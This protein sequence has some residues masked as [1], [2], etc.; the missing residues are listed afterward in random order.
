MQR[1]SDALRVASSIFSEGLAHLHADR[2]SEALS[3]FEMVE[4][5]HQ[6]HLQPA[7]LENI[8]CFQQIAAVHDKLGNLRQAAQY[9]ERAKDQLANPTLVPTNERGFTS[10]RRRAELLK[11]VQQQLEMMPRTVE[12][13]VG[14]GV[15]LDDLRALYTSLTTAGDK[16][17]AAGD[18]EAAKLSFEQALALCR[19][20]PAGPTGAPAAAPEPG[21]GN[22]AAVAIADTLARLAEVHSRMGRVMVAEAHILTAIDVLAGDVLADEVARAEYIYSG[23]GPYPHARADEVAA[24]E[25]AAAVDDP[26]AAAASNGSVSPPPPSILVGVGN[27]DPESATEIAVQTDGMPPRAPRQTH[28]Q[29]AQHRTRSPPNTHTEGAQHPTLALTDADAQMPV[30]RECRAARYVLLEADRSFGWSKVYPAA[31]GVAEA[32]LV[33]ASYL[34]PVLADGYMRAEFVG[35]TATEVTVAAPGE[36]VW[37]VEPAAPV[38][39][40]WCDVL[41]Q[42]GLRGSVPESHVAWEAAAQE[43]DDA[44]DDAAAAAIQTAGIDDDSDTGGRDAAHSSLELDLPPPL[45]P[46]ATAEAAAARR[47][48]LDSLRTSLRSLQ[49]TPAY[50][51]ASRRAGNASPSSPFSPMPSPL[52]APPRALGAHTPTS[53]PPH[54]AA[55]GGE[56]MSPPFRASP[57]GAGMRT[58]PS[59]GSGAPVRKFTPHPPSYPPPPRAPATPGSSSNPPHRRHTPHPP[60]GPPPSPSGG[61]GASTP[62]RTP[63]PPT[64]ACATPVSSMASSSAMATPPDAGGQQSLESLHA[65]ASSLA[66]AA[67]SAAA[68][69]GAAQAAQSAATAVS[70]TQASPGSAGAGSSAGGAHGDGGSSAGPDGSGDSGGGSGSGG[71][72]GGG[73]GGGGGGG[74][75]SDGGGGSGSGG[76][77]SAEVAAEDEFAWRRDQEEDDGGGPIDDR[78]EGAIEAINVTRDAMTEAQLT[79]DGTQRKL[80]STEAHTQSELTRLQEENSLHLVKLAEYEMAKAVSAEA[81]QAAN[82]AVGRVGKAGAGEELKRSKDTQAESMRMAMLLQK[83]F[84]AL[85]P[86]FVYRSVLESEL[87]DKRQAV[88]AA[89]EEARA[90]RRAYNRSMDYLEQISL[91]IQTKEAEERAAKEKEADEAAMQQMVVGAGAPA[92]VDAA[93]DPLDAL[94]VSEAPPQPPLSA[95]AGTAARAMDHGIRNKR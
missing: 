67:R 44:R 66:L 47:E 8:T 42:S 77:A 5:I 71:G 7:S 39:D 83:T 37:K 72:G 50:S 38:V 81:A 59:G 32:G 48:R 26:P 95:E 4:N 20:R 75:G 19:S 93:A 13:K 6:K 91:E 54:A 29:G 12:P 92:A 80:A 70:N 87:E 65:T 89:Q 25:A 62:M 31:A 43:G 86:Y 78:V 41:L 79:L 60:S 53:A 23:N 17:L 49:A 30:R 1:A 21:L 73:S 85:V 3:N 76:G 22:A 61:G 27:F 51:R 64:Q 35:Q 46:V 16:Q 15:P 90:R 28:H 84:D 82:E 57:L 9:L 24:D 18:L 69:V 52:R 88:A 55:S 36:L 94:D 2:L 63:H 34:K 10:R 11:H 14:A 33:P 40:G 56:M 68:A 58:A 45:T 74:S